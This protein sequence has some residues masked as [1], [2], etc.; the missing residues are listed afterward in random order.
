[1]SGA[2]PGDLPPEL[3]DRY[4][5]ALGVPRREP[6]RGALDELVAAHLT[7]VP[8]E[9]LSKLYR[10][11]RLGLAGLPPLE[12]F[13]E[14]IERHRLGGTCYS[15]NCHLWSLLTSLGYQAHL[16][17]A[18]M[19]QPDVH[20]V[21]MVRLDGRELLVDAGYGAPFLSP[22]PLDVHEDQAI[23][24]GHESYLLRPRD[25][26]G[27][28]RLELVVD[29][30]VTH[31]Y[32]ARPTPRLPA[33]FEGVIAASFRPEATFMNAVAIYRFER[34]RALVIRNLRLI[35]ATRRE[36]T[37]RALTDRRE[38]AE[39]AEARF[40]IPAAIVAEAVEGMGELREIWG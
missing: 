37:S 29:G 7:R 10:L 35:E 34:D 15:N 19:S 14:G 23:A 40:G 6:G 20:V 36:F 21:I 25:A 12:L 24:W 18:D 17:G 8:F 2:L 31:G 30:V 1:M 38:L 5:A 4:L 22:L 28:S 3:V 16:C 32:L 13:L 27:C 39:V 26:A 9:N 11:K 33:H